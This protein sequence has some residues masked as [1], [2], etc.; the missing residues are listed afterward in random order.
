M[1]RT[2]SSMSWLWVDS[3]GLWLMPAFSPRV[4]SIACGSSSCSFI[5]SWPAPLGMRC[6]GRP[7]AATARSQRVRH[8]GAQ[9]AAAARIVSSRC[10]VTPRRAQ[11]A[12][13]SACT[14][15]AQASRTASVVARMSRLKRQRPGTTLI[16]PAGT[17]RMPTVATRSGTAAP[18]RS[19]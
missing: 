7:S 6:T 12:S 19:T 11:I 15:R 14:S 2:A 16:E 13:S 5:A 18:R 9:G 4:N 10:A 17:S 1:A 3:S 8:S